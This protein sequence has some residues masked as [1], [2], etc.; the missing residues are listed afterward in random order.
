MKKSGMYILESVSL[1]GVD[2]VVIP[3]SSVYTALKVLKDRLIR[4]GY[5]VSGS[6]K[7]S[8]EAV[9]SNDHD[10]IILNIVAV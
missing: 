8:Y 5:S 7:D 2:R 3:T 9:R 1:D 6:I 10:R 4:N